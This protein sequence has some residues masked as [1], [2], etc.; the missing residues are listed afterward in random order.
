MTE[1]TMV[2]DPTEVHMYS[3]EPIMTKGSYMFGFIEVYSPSC[4]SSEW[5]DRPWLLK[6]EKD[7]Q[8]NSPGIREV[9]KAD[10]VWE[11]YNRPY[12]VRDHHRY[13]TD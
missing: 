13:L 5:A 7:E 2:F 6:T 4:D 10:A 12:F 8:G 9:I 3:K 11:C 1:A